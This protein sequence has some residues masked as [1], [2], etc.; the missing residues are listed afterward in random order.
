MEAV[1]GN[2]LTHQVLR[3]ALKAQSQS[4]TT[5]DSLRSF[6]GPRAPRLRSERN[7][8]DQTI[9]NGKNPA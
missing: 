4:R 3:L 6:A 8:D 1:E 2:I 7:F 5:L 9:A